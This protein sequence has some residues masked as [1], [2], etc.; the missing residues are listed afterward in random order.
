M[1]F[2]VGIIV[3]FGLL[4]A[5][6]RRGFCYIVGYNGPKILLITGAIGTPIHE[7]GHALMCLIFGH[8]IDEIKLFDPDNENGTLG[9][10]SHSYNPR[11]IY[12]QIGNF[13]IGIAPVLCGSGVL[14]LLMRLLVP[15]VFFTVSDTLASASGFSF[16]ALWSIISA[17]F[18]FSNFGDI[19]WWLFILLALMICSH[20]ELS[21]ADI[22]GGLLGLAYIAGALLIIDAVLYLVWSPAL[23]WLTGAMMSFAIPTASFLAISGIFSVLLIL[24]ALAIK[25]IGR[26]LGR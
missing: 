4:I 16:G 9:Y 20:M 17:M 12:H 15:E 18:S 14:I 22:K 23:E 1:L 21:G 10:V 6:C 11:N 3:V 13:F 5:L 25:G 26:L 24:I 7:L 2:T 8:R 19:L